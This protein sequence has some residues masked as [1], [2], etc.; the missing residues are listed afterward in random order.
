MPVLPPQKCHVYNCPFITDTIKKHLF[1]S[2]PEISIKVSNHST[3]KIS[4]T[5]VSTASKAVYLTPGPSYKPQNC[6]SLNTSVFFFFFFPPPFE[7]EKSCTSNSGFIMRKCLSM[8]TQNTP[9]KLSL[10]TGTKLHFT[11]QD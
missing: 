6:I 8:P 2:M 11:L 3:E 10:F 4:S 1:V 5:S 7:N 9:Y